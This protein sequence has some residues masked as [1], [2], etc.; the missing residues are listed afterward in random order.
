MTMATYDT[1]Y[2]A[3]VQAGYKL[4]GEEGYSELKDIWKEYRKTYKAESGESAPTLYSMANNYK[5][6]T[7]TIDFG[8]E[9]ITNFVNH[10]ETIYKD[11]VAFI[12]DNMDNTTHQRGQLPSLAYNHL[13]E[14]VSMYHDILKEIQVYLDSGVPSEIIAQAIAD[15][16]ELD[17]SIAVALQPPSDV[18]ILFEHTL[19]QIRG[20][21]SQIN[22]RIEELQE[23]AERELW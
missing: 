21:W 14:I 18:I 22:T 2:K 6:D 1:Y 9:Y 17:Y 4:T 19:E 5:D 12:Y 15:N 23:Q 10:L 3:L 11:T 7:P 20:I 8:K 16:V 13:D